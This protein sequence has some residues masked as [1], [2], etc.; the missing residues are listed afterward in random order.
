MELDSAPL[1]GLTVPCR[2]GEDA[3]D[4]GAG[5]GHDPVSVQLGPTLTV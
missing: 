5:R 4:L 2:V 3:D 1:P